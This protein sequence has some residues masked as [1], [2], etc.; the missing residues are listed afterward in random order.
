V[1]RPRHGEVDRELTKPI[2]DRTLRRMAAEDA[3][4][5]KRRAAPRPEFPFAT[6]SNARRRNR[7]NAAD[8]RRRLPESERPSIRALCDSGM[9]LSITFDS[10]KRGGAPALNQRE[11]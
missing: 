9:L 11:A 8:R 10:S 6:F 1:D 2:G 7:P 5:L 3:P 4:T